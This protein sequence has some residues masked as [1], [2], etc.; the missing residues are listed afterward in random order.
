MLKDLQRLWTRNLGRDDRIIAD[1]G[2]E[3][4]H[5][6]LDDGLLH[7][8]G[9]LPIDLLAFGPGGEAEPLPDK[10]LLRRLAADLGLEFCS[11][12]KKRAIQFGTRIARNSN[13]SHTGS[14]G[15]VTGTMLY[16]ALTGE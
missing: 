10:W 5:P 7:L 9:N 2:R 8:V 15:K 16:S 11:K 13:I 6:F 12:F 1:H 3:A 4:R 14:N